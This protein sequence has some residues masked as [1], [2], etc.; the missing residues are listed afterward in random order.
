MR[1]TKRVGLYL[2][3]ITVWISGALAEEPFRF[4]VLCDSRSEW[5]TQKCTDENSG[6]SPI[7]SVVVQHILRLH[8]SSPIQLILFPGDLIAGMLKRDQ[9]TVADCNIVQLRRWREIVSP[10]MENGIS[11]R[12]T[13]GNHE[14]QSVELGMES[15][16]NHNWAYIPELANFQALTMVCGDMRAGESGPD[17][18]LGWTYSFDMGPAHF[19]LLS[20]YTLFENNSFS[21]QTISWLIK[22]LQK[23]KRAGRILFVA[24]HAPAFPGSRH[25]TNSLSFYDPTYHCDGYGPPSGIDRRNQ[26]D[27]FWN[28]LKQHGVVAYFCGHEHNIQVQEVEGV[29]HV[30]SAGL[31]PQL[32][33]LNGADKSQKANTILYDGELQ[34]PR[35]SE[36]WPWSYDKKAYWGYVLVTL[37]GDEATMDVYGTTSFP[38]KPEDFTLVKTFQLRHR[39]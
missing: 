30:V 26:R 5:K 33:G 35:A 10:L 2:L 20:S 19:V 3:I 38:E 32:Y 14:V 13:P 31:T 8:Q 6:V 18:D 37:D 25:M 12:V 1:A 22:D 11:L 36:L 21:N 39:R 24:S 23:A 4:A 28:I 16:G 17:S 34:N 27:R 9:A 29:W 15:C 7:L